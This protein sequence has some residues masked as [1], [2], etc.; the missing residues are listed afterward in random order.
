MII[1]IPTGKKIDARITPF[2]VIQEKEG[3]TLI[4]LES[5]AKEFSLPL[6]PL[7]ARIT[8]EVHSSLESVGLTAFVS[9]ALAQEHI[10]A[11]MVAG[12]YHDH[13]LVPY[14]QGE[15]ALE[16]VQKLSDATPYDK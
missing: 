6:G 12:Y 3:V 16:I 11:N 2:A 1:S 10:S 7:F 15:K 14:H 9:R 5:D 13:I 4:L 8:L